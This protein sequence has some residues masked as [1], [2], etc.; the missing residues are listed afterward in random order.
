MRAF[1][2]ASQIS[3]KVTL[4]IHV[5]LSSGGIIIFKYIQQIKL[6]TPRVAPEHS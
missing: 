1:P 3:L 6:V 5:I 4:K 2:L